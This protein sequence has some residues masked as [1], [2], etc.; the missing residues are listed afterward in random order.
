MRTELVGGPV[1]RIRPA[2]SAITTAAATSRAIESTGRGWF[3]PRG[4]AQDAQG[5]AA[6]DRL[7][8][9]GA[10]AQRL[11]YLDGL[12]EVAHGE[13]VVAAQHEAPGA[14]RLQGT[15]QPRQ[16]EVRVVV[17]E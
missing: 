17:E 10:E 8:V 15:A 9:R 3:S 11:D 16:V 14:D 4:L 5:V 13:R 6:L 2:P 7:A 12:V 1:T